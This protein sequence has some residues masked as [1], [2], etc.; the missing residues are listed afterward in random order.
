M[1]RSRSVKTRFLVSIGTNLIRSIV[2]FISSLVIA[3]SFGPS[4]YGDLAFLLG[5]FSAIL[6]LLDMGAANAFYTF[7][8]RR[9]QGALFYRVYFFWI[10]FQFLFTLLFIALIIP[11]GTFDRL[12]L[13]HSKRIVL[14]ALLAVFMQQQVWQ[15]VS[16]IGESM[17]ATLKVQT[18]NL[19]V[20]ITYLIVVTLLSVSANLSLV[21]IMTLVIAQYVVATYVAYWILGGRKVAV[22]DENESVKQLLNDYFVFCRP[23]ML[24]SLVLFFYN[25]TDK[26]LLQ[27]YGGAIQQ[28]YFQIS[29]QFA[30]ISLI[31]TTSILS[32]FWKEIAEAWEKQDH[33][34][35]E[36]LYRKVSR[37][38]VMLGAIISG[39]LIPWAEQIVAFFLGDTYRQAWPVLA[40]MLLYPI[41]QSM[42]QIAGT[43]LLA[44]G[45]TKTHMLISVGGMLISIP[46]TFFMLAPASDGGG[47]M[48][49]WGIALKSVLLG[50]IS[51]NFQAWIIARQSGWKF[52]WIFQLIGIPLMIFIGYI[53]KFFVGRLWNLNDV[54]AENLLFPVML[55]CFLYFVL[56][57][58]TIWV[59]PWLVGL[60]KHDVARV[61]NFIWKK[62]GFYSQG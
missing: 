38:L 56:V 44:R 4:T 49:A 52:D 10:G 39:L 3:R 47:S 30:T 2:G 31:A 41:H 36:R 62:L 8:S 32:V 34:R 27:K 42:G 13:G 17:R 53:I 57:L 20:A 26:W 15:T 33:V 35:V 24:L 59:L 40:I 9:P 11:D 58:W 12:W 23:L 54:S 37:A 28:G 25:F 5:S 61:K 14:V 1:I 16:Q 45:Q 29:N 60:E 18:L 19:F 51:V 46:V 7:L 22:L 21:N 50:F 6:S 43:M 48:G 55:D